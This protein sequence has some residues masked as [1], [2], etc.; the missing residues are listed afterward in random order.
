VEVS[1]RD[2]TLGTLL[3][4]ACRRKADIRN[5]SRDESSFSSACVVKLCHT[6]PT[7]KS[8]L[9]TF[10]STTNNSKSNCPCDPNG[11][12]T[13]VYSRGGPHTA[14]APRPSLIYCALRV[15]I[16]RSSKSLYIYNIEETYIKSAYNLR[17]HIC[18]DFSYRV[19]LI[20]VGVCSP[21]EGPRDPCSGLG[22]PALK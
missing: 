19:C 21:S 5:R 8:D 3:T 11:K 10:L 15:P 18:N 2:V 12:G 6:S 13:Y 16:Q 17:A 1:G 22:A 9:Q 20:I 14:L 7:W 4:F